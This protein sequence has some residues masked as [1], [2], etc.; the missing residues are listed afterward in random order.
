M[1]D[2]RVI[3]PGEEL[4]KRS[5]MDDDEVDSIVD[6]LAALRTWREA[7]QAMSEESQ[8]HMKLNATDMKALRFLM[9]SRNTGAVV[10]PGL[11]AETLKISTASTTKLLDRL[12]RAGHVLRSPH[13]TDRRALAITITDATRTDARESVGRM[14]ARRF[15]AVAKLTRDERDV[16]VRFLT[17][18][19]QLAQKH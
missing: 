3:D 1:L 16:V 10:T 18:L 12:E 2:P 9:A 19:S 5:A 14:H 17:D 13:P 6:V 4:V 7:E 15:E 11:L 8:R